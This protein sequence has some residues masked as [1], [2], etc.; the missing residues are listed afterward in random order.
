MLQA[1]RR[2]RAQSRGVIEITPPDEFVSSLID[3]ASD[4]QQFVK[5]KARLR[6]RI[7]DHAMGPGTVAAIS[8][9]ASSGGFLYR[10]P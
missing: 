1:L 4:T 7:L 10:A 9:I 6:N 5:I 2:S 3:G 8:S